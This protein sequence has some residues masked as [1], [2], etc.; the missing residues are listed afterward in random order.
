MK[1]D[2][3]QTVV[4]DT[5]AISDKEQLPI[6]HLGFS[7]KMTVT[8][9]KAGYKTLGDL[10]KM[11]RRKAGE[12]GIKGRG[13]GSVRETL[14]KYG[15]KM[16]AD[17]AMSFSPV[18]QGSNDEEVPEW[19]DNDMI[20]A[21]LVSDLPEEVRRAQ[22]DMVKN[23]QRLVYK[24]AKRYYWFCEGGSS[25]DSDQALEIYDLFQAGRIGLWAATQ[26]FDPSLGFKFSTYAVW[27]I[28]QAISREVKNGGRI[29]IPIHMRDLINR[30][31]AFEAAQHDGLSLSDSKEELRLQMELNLKAF[32]KLEHAVRLQRGRKV[33][34]TQ[35]IGLAENDGGRTMSD[36]LWSPSGQTDVVVGAGEFAAHQEEVDTEVVMQRIVGSVMDR[37]AFNGREREVI[38][39]RFALFN[40]QEETLEEVGQH[41]GITRERVRQIEV[42]GLNKLR[43]LNLWT[44]Y[45]GFILDC[46]GDTLSEEQISY[47]M[48]NEANSEAELLAKQELRKRLGLDDH[49]ETNEQKVRVAVSIE[50]RV[51]NSYI[52]LESEETVLAKLNGWFGNQKQSIE[53][54]AQDMGVSVEHIRQTELKVI[55]KLGSLGI[56]LEGTSLPVVEEVVDDRPLDPQAVLEAV[57]EYFSVRKVQFAGWYAKSRTATYEFIVL[58]GLLEAKTEASDEEIARLLNYKMVTRHFHRQHNNGS[59]RFWAEL[60]DRD[61]N[62]DVVNVITL[63]KQKRLRSAEVANA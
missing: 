41:F 25:S 23:N 56:K 54:V 30:Y 16:N 50:T 22:A 29:R 58:I 34:L 7:D 45:S 57:C 19:V 18:V 17:K 60:N 51:R 2:Q 31:M 36:I 52:L 24:I 44:Q 28:R 20:G 6:E 49:R 1:K 35:S 21:D 26:K 13:L 11:N 62:T 10:V 48:A 53:Q 9:L 33:S 55:K 27:W 63:A 8:L 3:Q 15:M 14:A 47:F 59:L 38:I 37:C 46:F 5:S 42:V 4:F 32:E 12:Q 43:N 39:R 61:V 40:G